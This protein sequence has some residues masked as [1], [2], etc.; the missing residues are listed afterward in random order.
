[1]SDAGLSDAVEAC[2]SLTN[3]TYLS[4]G[5]G[6]ARKVLT[7]R[8]L[9]LN[10]KA[11]SVLTGEKVSAATGDD[12]ERRPSSTLSFYYLEEKNSDYSIEEH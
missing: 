9:E 4:P 1:M 7:G 5:L 2:T 11:Q 8:P 3:M 10:G 6:K 12:E